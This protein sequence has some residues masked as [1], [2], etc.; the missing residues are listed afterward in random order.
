MVIAAG[1]WRVLI[2]LHFRSTIQLVVEH[3]Y[4]SIITG[5]DSKYIAF[6]KAR[7]SEFLMYDLG[8]I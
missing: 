6:V 1:F 7:H 5:D 2:I 3:F 4:M 8:P